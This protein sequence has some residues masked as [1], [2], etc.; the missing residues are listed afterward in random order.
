MEHPIYRVV[1]FEMTGPYT[2]RIERIKL[3]RKHFAVESNLL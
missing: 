1:Q 2:L 3:Y